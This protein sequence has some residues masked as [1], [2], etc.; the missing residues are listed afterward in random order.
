M[1]DFTPPLRFSLL[2]SMFTIC[3]TPTI[4]PLYSM[5]T[6][7]LHT[8]EFPLYIQCLQYAQPLRFP[9]YIQCLQYALPI[10]FFI[11][12]L[13]YAPH[14]PLYIQCLQY[15]T[16]KIFPSLFN[17]YNMPSPQR[18]SQFLTHVSVGEI[19]AI[20]YIQGVVDS[21]QYKQKDLTQNKMTDK[22]ILT[23]VQLQLKEEITKKN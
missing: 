19:C 13:H 12:C 5:F 2:Y 4:S 11:Q 6:I 10:P 17:V 20:Y 1:S 14:F 23:L 21:L 8:I 7:C 15:A 18:F 3:P 22:C 16:T 9:L